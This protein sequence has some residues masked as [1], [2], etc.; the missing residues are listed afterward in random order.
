MCYLSSQLLNGLVQVSTLSPLGKV[1]GPVPESD[2]N[3]VVRLD[4]IQ[5][6]VAVHEDFPNGRV[7]EFGN[8]PP[9]L[10]QGRQAGCRVECAS[11]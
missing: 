4:A 2:D 1:P 7:V 5:Q 3:N 11:E 8:N 9:A 10:G 6:S